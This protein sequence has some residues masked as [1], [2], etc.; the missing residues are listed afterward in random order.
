M[1]FRFWGKRFLL[2]KVQIQEAFEKKL[3]VEESEEES[4]REA[5]RN[6]YDVYSDRVDF[7][8]AE[9]HI[10]QSKHVNK[11]IGKI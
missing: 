10:A 1:I 5:L 2:L 6:G 9:Y 3:Y 7:E 11:I 8:E 4:I